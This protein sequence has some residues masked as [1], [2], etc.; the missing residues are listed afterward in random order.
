MDRQGQ[1][2]REG[3]MAQMDA[4]MGRDAALHNERRR[5][6]SRSSLVRPFCRLLFLPFASSSRFLLPK[7]YI[8][9]DT[10]TTPEN[11]LPKIDGSTIILAHVLQRLTTPNIHAMLPGPDYAGARLFGTF[12]TFGVSLRVYPGLKINF[13]ES[14]TD[15]YLFP[16]L[17]L[18]IPAFLRAL[19]SFAPHVI[20]LVDPIWLGMQ[21]LIAL[22]ILFPTTPIVTSHYTN[23]PTSAEIFGGVPYELGSVVLRARSVFP[24]LAATVNSTTRSERAIIEWSTPSS[25]HRTWQIHSS[26]HHFARCT[27]VPSTSTAPPARERLGKPERGGERREWGGFIDLS[28][29]ILHFFDLHPRLRGCFHPPSTLHD[30]G[31]DFDEGRECSFALH[32]TLLVIGYQ[33]RAPSFLPTM[34]RSPSFS[35]VQHPRISY[36]EPLPHLFHIPYIVPSTFSILSPLNRPIFLALNNPFSSPS[37]PPRSPPR[38]I[39]HRLPSTFIF[40]LLSTHRSPALR[41]AWGASSPA[42][43]VVLSVGRLSLEKNLGLVV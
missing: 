22:Q 12:G 40:P 33:S 28:R 17:Q 25:H 2:E 5:Y 10:S 36:P 13:D 15:I 42:D 41:L 32:F 8:L 35:S 34:L 39:L 7:T 26:L 11:F 18:H 16:L 38:S 37:F 4:G 43:L 27:L 30:A 23:L 9:I 31:V 21:A 1:R 14:A 6:V 29:T 19:R 3:E 20:H 24:G